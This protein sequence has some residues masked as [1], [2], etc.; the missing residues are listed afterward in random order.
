MYYVW[1][2][3]FYDE[4]CVS[5][6]WDD[7]LI[8][9]AEF[10]YYSEASRYASLAYRYDDALDCADDYNGCGDPYCDYCYP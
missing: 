10:Y 2:D 8:V 6:D 3:W 7:R 1:Y 9:Y 5:H 4:Y